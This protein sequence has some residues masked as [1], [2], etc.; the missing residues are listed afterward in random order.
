MADRIAAPAVPSE[1]CRAWVEGHFSLE[2]M[3]GRY[4]E[5]YERATRSVSLGAASHG[6]D[7]A[8]LAGEA[9]TRSD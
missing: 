3:V 9:S 4:L 2:V 8:A 1:S 7:V 6:A 5:L